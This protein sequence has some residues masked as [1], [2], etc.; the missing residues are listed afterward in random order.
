MSV[1]KLPYKS[2]DFLKEN[3]PNEYDFLYSNKN[4]NCPVQSLLV[5]LLTRNEIINS[6]NIIK[7]I[8][9]LSIELASAKCKCLYSSDFLK[10]FFLKNIHYNMVK[11]LII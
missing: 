6:F 11:I 8:T 4:I 1:K 2:E 7:F 10:S 5:E 9:L 3:R